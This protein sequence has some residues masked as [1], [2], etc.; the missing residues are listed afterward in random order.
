MKTIL[1]IILTAPLM[2]AQINPIWSKVD[3]VLAV[4]PYSAHYNPIDS[5]IYFVQ[6]NSGQDG[7]Y[8]YSTD[9]GVVLICSAD[10]PSA[11]LVDPRDG[12]IFHSEGYGGSIFYTP[13]NG[14]GR[15]TWVSGFHSGDDDPIGMAIVPENYK[16]KGLLPGQIVVVDRGNTGPDEIWVFSA[17]SA[18]NEWPLHTDNGTLIN[19]LDVA[20]TDSN[21]YIVDEG[22]GS[23]G[24]IFEVDSAGVLTQLILNDT[25]IWP[26]GITPDPIS[27]NLYVLDK[28]GSVLEVNPVNGNVEEIMT[29]FHS[30]SFNWCGID[31]SPAGDYLI[32][33]EMPANYINIFRRITSTVEDNNQHDISTFELCQN[34]PNPFNPSTKISWQSPVGSWQTIKLFDVLGRELETIVDGYYNSGVHSTLYIVNS[35]LPSGVYFYQ[36]KAGDFVQTKKMIYLK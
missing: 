7:V 27:G 32:I 15:I 13:F 12:D 9:S 14:T 25:L 19:P 24:G 5:A 34:Y 18:E 33:T 36:L 21:V 30:S 17:D 1:L 20:I 29:G 16:G 2:I 22:E 23:P 4:E 3:S 6:S 10:R 28:E 8:K 31:I 11:L 26:V 35:T